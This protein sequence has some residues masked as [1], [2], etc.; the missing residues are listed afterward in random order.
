M[1]EIMTV[2]L[3]EIF[4]LYQ[5]GALRPAPATTYR[6][7][8]FSKALSDLKDRRSGARIVLVPDDANDSPA[9]T[10]RTNRVARS[11]SN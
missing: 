10:V 5:D 1:P 8:D 4:S 11:S 3:E 6:L 9:L 2:C 7:A